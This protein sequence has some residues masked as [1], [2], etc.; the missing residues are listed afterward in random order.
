M[1]G[2]SSSHTAGAL[3][4]S[5]MARRLCQAPPARAKFT[6][7]GSFAYTGVGHGT[8]KALVAGILGLAADDARIRTSFELAREMGV[9]VELDFNRDIEPDHPNTV[10][11]HVEMTDGSELDVRGVSI[12]G[13]AAVIVRIDGVDVDITGEH[14][15]IVVQQNDVVGVLAHIAGVMADAHV[16][17]ASARLY[18]TERHK[19]AFTVMEVDS[20]RLPDITEQLYANPNILSVRIIPSV[21]DDT[22]IGGEG[23]AEGAEGGAAGTTGVG[24]SAA[25]AASASARLGAPVAIAD[26]DTLEILDA[27]LDPGSDEALE[28]F[29]RWDFT[30][31]EE[32]L[33]VCEREGVKISEVFERR[34][35]ALCALRGEFYDIDAYLNRVLEVMKSEATEPV[36]EPT[37]SVGGLIGGE[38]QQVARATGA[39]G[40]AGGD[41]APAAGGNVDAASSV[42]AGAA[43]APS[44]SPRFTLVDPLAASAITYALATLE[45]NASMGRIVA[46]PTAGSAGVLPGALLALREHRGVSD[47]ELKCGLLTCAAIGSIIARNA[48]VS[49][50]EGGCQAEV[51]SA[52]GMAAAAAVE[53]AGGTPRQS[54]F[55]GSNAL[56]NL[57]GL[58]CDPV[59]GL[60]ELPC[61]K[62]NASAALV[63]LVSA[64]IALSGVDNAIT[65]DDTVMA[66]DAVG[67]SLPFELRESALGGIAAVPSACQACGACK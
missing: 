19:F 27:S 37:R 47:A 34:E 33:E 53:L 38:A 18:R 59:G 1:I 26:P 54:L 7:Y 20:P 2:P 21:S 40:A 57:M 56:M 14:T 12:G 16:N 65:F 64:Q 5:A 9:E 8:D 28:I 22:A 4:I 49:G 30:S 58:V 61:Q 25:G 17:I 10:D 39:S 41:G 60:V 13:G 23:A 46:T 11:I 3:A 52:A 63:A 31:G 44:P 51:G 62:R 45:T 36:A 32:L 35:R 24:V 15:S 67:R 43:V 42:D 29:E 48:S 66:M 50:A 6:L 55:A